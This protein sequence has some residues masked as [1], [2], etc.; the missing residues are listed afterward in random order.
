MANVLDQ[1]KALDEQ[2][3]QLISDA[4]EE[5]LTKANAAIEELNS[6]GF[7]YRLVE[8][9]TGRAGGRKGTRSVKDAA[10]PVCNFK[11]DP[12]HDRRK[13]R[14]Q[15]DDKVPFTNAELADLGLSRVGG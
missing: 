2:R 1:L 14:A 3:A 9:G 13:H 7:S 15:G 10:C 12:P 5:S 8:G 11:T 4:K 6:L